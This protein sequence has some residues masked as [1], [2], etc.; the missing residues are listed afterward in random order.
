MRSIG[1]SAV[2]AYSQMP[3]TLSSSSSSSYYH[4]HQRCNHHHHHI[5]HLILC[6]SVCIPVSRWSDKKSPKSFLSML[7]PQDGGKLPVAETNWPESQIIC[8]ESEFWNTPIYPFWKL[9]AVM[10]W[11][12]SL[13][14][15]QGKS[16][17][18]VGQQ[19]Q[20][21]INLC[22]ASLEL[23]DGWHIIQFDLV[24]I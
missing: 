14:K 23:L 8:E 21:G 4:N 5:S 17:T 16:D 3:S 7:K 10:N 24:I 19:L 12:F 2:S 1:L 6:S 22:I 15:S 9:N 18:R 20:F 13:T 11:L